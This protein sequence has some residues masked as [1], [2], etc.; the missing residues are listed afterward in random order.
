MR[1][2]CEIF[3]KNLDELDNAIHGFKS[4]LNI[5]TRLKKKRKKKLRLV[6]GSASKFILSETGYF[7]FLIVLYDITESQE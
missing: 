7:S 6:L 1:R 4:H 3:V 2:Y 5:L